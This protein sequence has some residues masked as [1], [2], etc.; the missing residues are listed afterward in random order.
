MGHTTKEG[1]KGRHGP[2]DDGD[3]TVPDPDLHPLAEL[4]MEN[5]NHISST[6]GRN[7]FQGDV[8]QRE[9]IFAKFQCNEP[10]LVCRFLRIQ[11]QTLISCNSVTEVQKN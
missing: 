10:G 8:E 1:N 5:F 4:H 6:L 2:E 11:E 7:W 3:F 9:V